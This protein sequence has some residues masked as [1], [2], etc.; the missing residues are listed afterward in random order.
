MKVFSAWPF[1]IEREEVDMKQF[2]KNISKE[3]VMRLHQNAPEGMSVQQ[4]AE[5]LDKRGYNVEEYS[6]RK[7]ERRYQAKV[8][9]Q[10]AR[11]WLLDDNAIGRDYRPGNIWQPS[12]RESQIHRQ[13]GNNPFTNAGKAMAAD[14][15][16]RLRDLS[17]LWTYAMEGLSSPLW[18][19]EKAIRGDMHSDSWI[20]SSFQNARQSNDEWADSTKTSLQHQMGVDPTATSTK[21]GELIGGTDPLMAWIAQIP[22]AVTN[23][24]NVW[25]HAIEWFSSPIWLAEKAMKW[26]IRAQSSIRD[27]FRQTRDES[28]ELGNYA[29]DVAQRGLGVEQWTM[30]TT[31]GEFI[32]DIAISTALTAGIWWTASAWAKAASSGGRRLWRIPVIK[33]LIQWKAWTNVAKAVTN[34]VSPWAVRAWRRFLWSSDDVAKMTAM[35]IKDAAAYA[36]VSEGEIWFDDILIW[37]A[38]GRVAGNVGVGLQKLKNQLS[39]NLPPKLVAT[40]LKLRP[41]KRAKILSQTY[42]GESAESWLLKN[43]FITAQ[44]GKIDDMTWLPQ[45]VDD[46]DDFFNTSYQTLN[47]KI[48]DIPE[49][50]AKGSVW[51]D[52]SK[53]ILKDM[54]AMFTQVDDA[55]R[56]VPRLGHEK[57]V[58]QI[59]ELFKKETMSL[60]D[61]LQTKRMVD[62]S[63][64]LY[65]TTWAVKE[66]TAAKGYATVR[67]EIR[68]FIEDESMRYGVNARKLSNNIQVSR[69]ISE[70]ITDAYSTTARNNLTWLTDIVIGGFGTTANVMRWG[71]DDTNLDN[72]MQWATWLAMGVLLSQIWRNPSLRMAL[73]KK[74]YETSTPKFL[75]IYQKLHNNQVVTNAERKFIIA[76]LK[77]MFSRREQRQRDRQEQKIIDQYKQAHAHEYGI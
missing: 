4:V 74:L 72:L 39:V 76:G 18:L 40:T 51:F 71:W 63:L 59:D 32:G 60:G 41:N 17:N 23:L 48:A 49:M 21:V 37:W 13:D 2:A 34:T 28:D 10:K 33:N 58:A 16:N 67:Q 65:K 62:Q 5:E 12:T 1:S 46:L 26:D 56:A 14:T 53:S 8:K 3:E 68:K 55:G 27:Y 61:I 73:A 11:E 57:T 6:D 77:S 29:K 38:F 19:A 70:A 44:A 69:E 54:Y 64:N 45:L 35:G 66:S 7:K 36:A 50:Y 22:Q 24:S 43:K 75:S 47:T 31:I 25:S 42:A 15:P 52:S 30:A 20:R 9:T